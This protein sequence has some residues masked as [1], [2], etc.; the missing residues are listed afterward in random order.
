[1]V[2]LVDLKTTPNHEARLIAQ[3]A[4]PIVLATMLQYSFQVVS[5]FTVGRLGNIELGAVSLGSMTAN[6]TAY[7]V[8]QGLATSLDTLCAQAYGS[9]H[10]TLV[11]LHCQKMIYLLWGV[12]IPIGILW[13][14]SGQI[15][16]AMIPKPETVELAA[17]YLRI[18]LIGAPGWAAFE[19]GKRFV[20]AQGIFTAI[21]Y[22]LLILA[23]LNVFL[24]WLFVWKFAWG[25]V[26]APFAVAIIN[27]LLPIGLILY[28]RFIAGRECW[29]GLSYAAF[30]DWTPMV[31]LALPGF[32][33][34]EG[35]W[36][37]FEILTLSASH[38]DSTHLA[39]QSVIMT[40]ANLG[41]QIPMPLSIAASTR[42]GNLIGAGSSSSAKLSAK[43][44][45]LIA[46]LTG[47]CNMIFFAALRNHIPFWF[48]ADV[49][50]AQIITQTLPVIAACQI[51]DALLNMCNGILRGIG[52]QDIGGYTGLAGYYLVRIPKI[53]VPPTSANEI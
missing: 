16:G 13:F 43:M 11:G 17:I 34:I 18:T 30:S 42:I 8:Y 20:Q 32:L 45:I 7:A 15:L 53:Y 10:K 48:T 19:S 33:M 1:M 2:A 39:A 44:A 5:V 37:A 24:H 21:L 36:M 9:G 29:G 14:F 41:S 27:L 26:G 49:G 31:K 23:P 22:V 25:F 38:L 47:S 35:E 12:T 40:M 4:W 28:V 3:Y 50:I 6:I 46:T 51:C 52:R